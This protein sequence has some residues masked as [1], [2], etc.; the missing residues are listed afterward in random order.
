MAISTSAVRAYPAQPEIYVDSVQRL[1]TLRS[2][3][4]LSLLKLA[5]LITRMISTEALSLISERR[6]QS[7]RGWLK[8]KFSRVAPRFL[9][10]ELETH[11]IEANFNRLTFSTISPPTFLRL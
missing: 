3:Q 8:A 10:Q 7:T 5:L 1:R 9:L 11:P 6:Q 2:N 4:Y